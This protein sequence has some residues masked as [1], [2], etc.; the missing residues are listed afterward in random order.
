MQPSTGGLFELVK[1]RDRSLNV[2]QCFTNNFRVQT[3]I[4]VVVTIILNMI[5]GL[6]ISV[7]LHLTFRN[8]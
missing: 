2:S 4:V 3:I 6:R 8:G 1:S 7:F 5:L